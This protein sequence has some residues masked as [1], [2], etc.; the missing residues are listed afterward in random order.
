MRWGLKSKEALAVTLLTLVVVATTL[1]VHL[2]QLTRVAVEETQRQAELIAKQIVAQSARA[3]ARAP[4]GDPRE[5]LR[6]DPELRNLL[7]ASVGY[8]PSRLYVLVAD[9]SGRGS[10]PRH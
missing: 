7:E 3:L 5:A 4:D 9:R 8:S 2:A 10:L 1:V 6:T